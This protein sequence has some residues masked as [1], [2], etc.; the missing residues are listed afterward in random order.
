M[1]KRYTFLFCLFLFCSSQA[2]FAQKLFALHHGGAVSFYTTLQN[3]HDAAVSGD[4]IYLPGGIFG[5]ISLT[6]SLT[7]IGVGHHPDSTLST[8]RTTL[9]NLDIHDAADNSFITG[10]NIT[11]TL[12]SNGNIAN[13]TIS[14]CY[15]GGGM[16]FNGGAATNWIIYENYIGTY[17]CYYFGPCGEFS[18]YYTGASST[19]FLLTNNIIQSHGGNFNLSEITHNVFLSGN[20]AASQSQ[21]KNNVF[22]PGANTNNSNNCEWLNNL[23]NGVNGTSGNSTGSGNYLDNAPLTSVFVSYNGSNTFYQNDFHVV[24]QTYLGNDGT[25]VGIYGGPF[26]WKVG[27]LPFTPHIRAKTISS[28]TNPDGTLHINITVKAQGN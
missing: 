12:S 3:A 15:L 26:P 13:V 17:Y 4:T 27:S 6:R 28:T 5:G 7:L 1:C 16:V 21:I 14:R 11:G 18:F 25:P 22:Y 2:S 10:I 24:N 9:S 19:N 23:N 20:L 8:G